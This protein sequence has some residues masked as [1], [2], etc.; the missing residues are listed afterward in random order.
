M[1]KFRENSLFANAILHWHCF[2]LAIEN[3]KIILT[4][5]TRDDWS[6]GK[7]ILKK[8]HYVLISQLLYE[9]H[10]Q[11]IVCI[12]NDKCHNQAT[13]RMQKNREPNQPVKCIEEA[14]L[15]YQASFGIC[16]PHKTDN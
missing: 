4:K 2:V 3:S 15:P 14:L 5:I 8:Q 6:D 12:F 9:T 1:R 13:E 11:H 16:L 10:L 7:C